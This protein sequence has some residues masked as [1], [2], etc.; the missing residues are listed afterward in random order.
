MVSGLAAF[1]KVEAYV[2]ITRSLVTEPLAGEIG[3]LPDAIWSDIN[4]ERSARS[5]AIC[6]ANRPWT[7]YLLLE[8]INL[9]AL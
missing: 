2:T 7:S 3:V 9:T 8:S 6:M 5:V 4:G 1:E